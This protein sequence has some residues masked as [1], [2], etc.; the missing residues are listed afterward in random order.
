MTAEQIADRLKAA[1][2]DLH[3]EIA[4]AIDEPTLVVPPEEIVAALDTLRQ[5]PSLQFALLSEVTAVDWWPGEPRYQVVY[6]LVSFE[7][8]ARLRVKTWVPGEEAHLPTVSTMWPGANWLEREVFDLFGIVFDGHPDL[9]RVLMPEDWEGHPLRK[10]YPVQIKLPVKIH[11]PI[12]VSPEE[13]RK[14]IEDDRR[15]RG[16]AVDAAQGGVVEQTKL[17]RE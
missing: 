5:S 7:N 1:R 11:E 6:H 15:T 4:P 3:V 16:H 17:T 12:Q 14:T 8:R 2:P 13:F 10:D 9:R